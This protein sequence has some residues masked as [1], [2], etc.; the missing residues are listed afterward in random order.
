M[1][2]MPNATRGFMGYGLTALLLLGAFPVVRTIMAVLHTSSG[3]PIILLGWIFLAGFLGA[4]VLFKGTE[5]WKRAAFGFGISL[6]M[7][8]LALLAAMESMS[9]ECIDCYIDRAHTFPHGLYFFTFWAGGFTLYGAIGGACKRL[10]LTPAGA[11]AFGLPATLS[12]YLAIPPNDIMRV[13]LFLAT[14]PLGGLL[15]GLVVGWIE[16][17]DD[18]VPQNPV[19]GDMDNVR[20][21]T[22]TAS[23]SEAWG[24]AKRS[25]TPTPGSPD[26]SPP[27]LR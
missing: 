12:G 8:S 22:T 14:L 23:L 15:F 24:G 27:S 19:S 9:D 11:V 5:H 2:P 13:V 6:V 3:T 26:V 21:D 7:L 1:K 25:R 20:S 17:R 10:F 16:E 18:T 4:A